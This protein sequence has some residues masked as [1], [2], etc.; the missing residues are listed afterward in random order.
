MPELTLLQHLLNIC[1][2]LLEVQV[3]TGLK[4]PLQSILW[5]VQLPGVEPPQ[6][7]TGGSGAA[8]QQQ[9]LHLIGVPI[10]YRATCNPEGHATAASCGMVLKQMCLQPDLGQVCRQAA[11]QAA[12]APANR[13]SPSRRRKRRLLL[14]S[15]HLMAA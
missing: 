6:Q 1:V 2:Q 8:S 9:L 12:C 10:P 3:L 11:R 7:A 14:D 5:Q 15:A 13:Y 4:A